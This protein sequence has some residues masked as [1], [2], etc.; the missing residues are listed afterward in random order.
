MITAVLIVRINRIHVEVNIIDAG[1][2]DSVTGS[3]TKNYEIFNFFARIFYLYFFAV[4]F[5]TY[6][7]FCF[8]EE[9]ILCRTDGF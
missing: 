8:R 4:T 7:V 2:S 9:K 5:V 6:H 1:K 3:Y